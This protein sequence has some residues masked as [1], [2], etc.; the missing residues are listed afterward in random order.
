MCFNEI[1]PPGAGQ[2]PDMDTLS[3]P[4]PPDLTAQCHPAWASKA[5]STLPDAGS[6]LTRGLPRQ[7]TTDEAFL[8]KRLRLPEPNRS[9]VAFVF[10]T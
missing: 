5:S 7:I 6:Q 8:D 1:S 4:C 9:P 2:G 10:I 3:A